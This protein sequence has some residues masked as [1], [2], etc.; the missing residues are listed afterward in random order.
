MPRPTPPEPRGA[1]PGVGLRP[2]AGRPDDSPGGTS[3]RGEQHRRCL[4]VEGEIHPLMSSPGSRPRGGRMPAI[5]VLCG[6]NAYRGL[7]EGLGPWRVGW[8]GAA[9]RGAGGGGDP[10]RLYGARPPPGPGLGPRAAGRGVG[11]R[12]A[13]ATRGGAALPAAGVRPRPRPLGIPP[14]PRRERPPTRSLGSGSTSVCGRDVDLGTRFPDI[15]TTDRAHLEAGD[16][17]ASRAEEEGRATPVVSGR[18]APLVPICS[19]P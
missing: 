9:R 12:G 10:R 7:A 4:G 14:A 6:R 18:R 13:A 3:E 16:D 15:V 8:S 19:V 1:A 5:N 2:H 11:S 17:A